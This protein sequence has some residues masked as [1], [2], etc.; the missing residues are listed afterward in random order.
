[1]KKK[2]IEI[3]NNIEKQI[4]LL[5]EDLIID[6]VGKIKKEILSTQVENLSNSAGS[7]GFNLFFEKFDAKRC[8]NFKIGS[9]LNKNKTGIYVDFWIKNLEPKGNER[10]NFRL[11]DYCTFRKIH[12]PEKFESGLTIEE[13]EKISFSEIEPF[14]KEYF[15]FIK[16]IISIEEV[17]KMLYSEYWTNVPIDYSPYK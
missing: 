2:I 7:F 9:I 16:N 14:L 8:L 13:K 11:K 17:K 15:Q 10:E 1:M 3:S 5:F 12:F 6:F 4:Y